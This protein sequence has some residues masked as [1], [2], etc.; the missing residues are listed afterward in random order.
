L[1]NGIDVFVPN[2]DDN[3]GFMLFWLS[4]HSFAK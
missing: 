1:H 4:T 3:V 2:N